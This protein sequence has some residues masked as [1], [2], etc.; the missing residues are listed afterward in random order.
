MW[1]QQRADS[2]ATIQS[3]LQ[4]QNLPRKWALHLLHKI[5]FRWAGGDAS[6]GGP[7]AVVGY[8]VDA[9]GG[10]EGWDGN[11]KGSNASEGDGKGGGEDES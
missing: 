5:Q 10:G 6:A 2:A 1:A 7:A 4:N 3:Q 11:D 8:V 9:V